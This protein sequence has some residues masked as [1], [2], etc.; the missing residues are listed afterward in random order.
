MTGDPNAACPFEG[1]G[2]G[3]GYRGMDRGGLTPP[4][5]PPLQGEGGEYLIPRAVPAHAS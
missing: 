3:G 1:E 5:D 4:P 2:W